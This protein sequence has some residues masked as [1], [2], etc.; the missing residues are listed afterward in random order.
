MSPVS[1]GWK[2]SARTV[3]EEVRVAVPLASLADLHWRGSQ[4]V[5]RNLLVAAFESSQALG[6]GPVDSAKKDSFDVNPD[7]E[8]IC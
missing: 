4:P 8:F 6:I 5:P 1:R 2:F 7:R 3:G